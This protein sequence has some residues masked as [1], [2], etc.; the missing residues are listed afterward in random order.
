MEGGE[1]NLNPSITYEERAEGGWMD[2]GNEL[3]SP[4]F[5]NKTQPRVKSDIL[6]IKAI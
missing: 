3:S 2:R 4:P 1:K 5:V 6:A